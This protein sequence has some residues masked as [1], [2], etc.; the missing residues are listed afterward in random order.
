MATATKQC[1]ALNHGLHPPVCRISI[2]IVSRAL[3]KRERGGELQLDENYGIQNNAFHLQ[4][5]LVSVRLPLRI[6]PTHNFSAKPETNW[7]GRGARRGRAV[8]GGFGLFFRMRR[9]NRALL[10]KK[11]QHWTLDCRMA[12][13]NLT[14]LKGAHEVDVLFSYV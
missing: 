5:R 6:P 1:C 4:S 11:L 2:V 13:I 14:D 12:D 7:K 3:R 9:I 10:L 8:E